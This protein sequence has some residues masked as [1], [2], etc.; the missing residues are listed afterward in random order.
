[1][2]DT[3]TTHSN[4]IQ[5][6][7]KQYAAAE[8]KGPTAWLN[9]HNQK[10][11]ETAAFKNLEK[12]IAEGQTFTLAGIKKKYLLTKNAEADLKTLFNIT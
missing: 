5:T 7:K 8:T 6:P 11:E 4:E 10:G 12:A 9:L 1:M 2:D 3:E